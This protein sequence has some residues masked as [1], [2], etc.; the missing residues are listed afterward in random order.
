MRNL[1]NNKSPEEHLVAET[2]NKDIFENIKVKFITHQGGCGG[3]RQDSES[4][5]RLLAGYVNNPNVT[6][7]TV[8]SLGCQNLQIELFKNAL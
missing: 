4:L 5:A 2:E 7:T 8:L 1:I 3:I 6:G